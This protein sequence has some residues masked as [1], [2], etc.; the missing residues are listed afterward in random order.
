MKTRGK[1]SAATTSGGATIAQLRAAAI[2]KQRILERKLHELVQNS[3]G[4]AK[5]TLTV[6]KFNPVTDPH[7]GVPKT[8]CIISLEPNDRVK[9]DTPVNPT[10]LLVT[11]NDLRKRCAPA[12]PVN[13]EFKIASQNSKETYYP[14]GVSFSL[15]NPGPAA[16][17]EQKIRSNFATGA[18]SIIGLSL[19]FTDNYYLGA[20]PENVYDFCVVVQC[21]SDGLIGVIDPCISH[22]P[23]PPSN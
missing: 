5:V 19:F 22:N 12:D 1:T 21:L 18:M 16:P 23:P 4:T 15:K 17:S 20:D 6:T 8:E 3:P 14:V 10:K 11:P 7:K 13:F 9:G 2:A